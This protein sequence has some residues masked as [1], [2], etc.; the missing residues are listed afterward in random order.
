MLETKIFKIL[1]KVTD[2]FFPETGRWTSGC[3]NKE[4]SS[5]YKKS[6]LLCHL[7][8]DEWLTK[9]FSLDV[10]YI[11]KKYIK[12]YILTSIY[13]DSKRK[14]YEQ[15]IV[16]WQIDWMNN[17][18]ENWIVDS[19]LGGDFY[20]FSP[21]CDYAF[22]K[23][24]L[25]TLLAI[26][27]NKDAI[28]EGIERNSHKWRE[29]HMIM[30][31][32]NI[33]NPIFYRLNSEEKLSTPNQEHFDKWMKMRLYEYYIKNKDSVDKYGEILPEMKI[34]DEEIKELKEWLKNENEK[35]L[36]EIEEYKNMNSNNL[37]LPKLTL[38]ISNTASDTLKDKT[39]CLI[40]RIFDKK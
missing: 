8:D 11:S 3:F 14:E 40:K 12:K 5:E 37:S 4:M 24:I 38:N 25:D 21:N 1:D 20:L 22:R 27:M 39:K 35:R 31:F 2:D 29:N 28:E 30:A 17:D 16:S 13:F 36:R 18:G 6:N 33:Y 34:S 19:K 10:P 26:G 9:T 15:K 7:R 23:G 32:N